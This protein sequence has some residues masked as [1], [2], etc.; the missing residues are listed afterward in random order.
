MTSGI[1]LLGIGVFFLLINFD[2]VDWESGWPLI[3]VI[4][5]L[6]LVLGAFRRHSHEP[7]HTGHPPT[8]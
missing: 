3:L 5:G 8:V 1:I 2:L 7:P 4:V 6:S